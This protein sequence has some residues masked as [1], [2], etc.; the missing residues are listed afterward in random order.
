M[1]TLRVYQEL[2]SY[3]FYEDIKHLKL[4]SGSYREIDGV[5]WYKDGYYHRKDGPAIEW[6]NGEKEWCLNGQDVF[7]SQENNLHLYD[8]LTEEFKMSII[9]YRLLGPEKE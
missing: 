2:P 1:K 7:N 5:Y 4:C 8:N 6:Y 3:L 9:K